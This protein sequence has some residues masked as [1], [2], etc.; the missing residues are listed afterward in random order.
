MKLGWLTGYALTICL[1]DD[2]KISQFVVTLASELSSL[3]STP[4]L[5]AACNY[6]PYHAVSSLFAIAVAHC[7]VSTTTSSTGIVTFFVSIYFL[8]STVRY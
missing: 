7:T 1:F 4:M 2:P 3:L 6:A 5:I 8:L